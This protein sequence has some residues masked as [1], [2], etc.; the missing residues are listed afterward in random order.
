MSFD[1]IRF[2]KEN[3][4]EYDDS[5]ERS[6][7]GWVNI[8]CPFCG[9]GSR[10]YDLGINLEGEYGSCW[11]CRGKSLQQVIKKLVHCSYTEA[12]KIIKH[13]HGRTAYIPKEIASTNIKKLELP[14]GTGPMQQQHDDYL[15]SRNFDP[16]RLERIYQLQGT[17]RIGDHKNRII[18]P[19]YFEN[20][21]ISY[22]GREIIHRPKVSGGFDNRWKACEK[23]LEVISHQHVLYGYDLVKGDTC[24]L[25]EGCSDTW[26]LGPGSVGMFGLGYTI[27][28]IN[29]LIKRFKRVFLLLDPEPQAQLIAEEIAWKLE[30]AGREAVICD[31]EKDCDPGDLDQDDA[32]YFMREIHLRGHN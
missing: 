2:L 18:V 13:Y 29:L 27:Q 31:L 21:L 25:I 30:Y 3:H 16:E 6:R 23:S 5:N 4:L 12:N 19:V 20:N 1:A 32:N 15:I 7:E 9:G 17:G 8:N 14:P 11:L 26:R 28:Q 10:G 22:Q 24:C